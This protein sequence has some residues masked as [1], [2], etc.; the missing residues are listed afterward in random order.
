MYCLDTSVIIAIFD[1]K[2]EISKKLEKISSQELFITPINLCEL[3]KGAAHSQI[4]QKR[5]QFIENLLQSVGILEFNEFCCRVF[6]EEYIKLKKLGK[7]VKDNDLMIA[8]ISMAHDKTLITMDK[9][10]FKN[11]KD[12]K[13]EI[14]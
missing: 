6:G 4:T 7:P 9:K 14:W 10:D 1:G 11:I 5:L 12:L 13:L 3:Y 2:E 8:A